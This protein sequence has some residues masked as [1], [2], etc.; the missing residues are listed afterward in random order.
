MYVLD[1]CTVVAGS[2]AVSDPE[3]ARKL[4]NASIGMSVAGI[5]VTVV[6]IIIAVAV[7]TS[8]AASSPYT[9]SSSLTVSSS[10]CSYEYN[11]VCYEY[12]RYVGTGGICTGIRDSYG[13][14]YYDY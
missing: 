3:G 2:S 10:S 14:C 1:V 7:V 11:S 8:A 13:Y 4:G 6:V 12:K 5:V 9:S